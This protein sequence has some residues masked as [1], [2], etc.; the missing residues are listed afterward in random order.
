MNRKADI[1]RELAAMQ[2]MSPAELRAKYAELFGEASRSGNRTW[3]LRRCACR[4]Q[5]MRDASYLSGPSCGP[6]RSPETRTFG[7][8]RRPTS[9]PKRHLAFS[10]GPLSCH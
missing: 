3:L 10:G 4:L 2:Q 1:E 6:S 5:A 9:R 7:P 8:G